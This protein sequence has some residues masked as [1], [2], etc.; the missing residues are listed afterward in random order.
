MFAIAMSDKW[1]R[2]L[3]LARDRL[4]KKPLYYGWVGNG[5]GRAFVFRSELK[6]LKAYPGSDASVCRQA[7]A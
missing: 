1:N 2:T 4:G 6:A 7:L 3:M 5:S